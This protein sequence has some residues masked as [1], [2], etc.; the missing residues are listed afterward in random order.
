MDELSKD[1]RLSEEVRKNH[2]L[3]DFIYVKCPDEILI[4]CLGFGVRDG[5]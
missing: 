1:I 3:H 4:G 5:K 2:T